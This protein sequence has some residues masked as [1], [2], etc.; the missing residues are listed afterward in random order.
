MMEGLTRAHGGDWHTQSVF[1]LNGTAGRSPFVDH[2]EL[3]T[4]DE[5]LMNAILFVM[6]KLTINLQL[7]NTPCC[8]SSILRS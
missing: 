3:S 8:F 4:V 7:A 1:T 2:V 6:Y 5:L